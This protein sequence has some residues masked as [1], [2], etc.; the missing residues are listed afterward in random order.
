M[1]LRRRNVPSPQLSD[2]AVS[3]ALAVPPLPLQQALTDERNLLTV[4]W[5]L[6]LQGMEQTIATPTYF[7]G[8]HADRKDPDSDAANFRLGAY[9]YETDRKVLYQS[10]LVPLTDPAHPTDP[11]IPTPCWVYVAGTMSGTLASRPTD[12]GKPFFGTLVPPVPAYHHDDTGFRFHATD[13]NQDYLW[14]GTAWI[15]VTDYAYAVYGTHA[16]RLAHSLSTL[17]D[18]TLWCEIDRNNVLYQLQGG[19]WWYVSGTMYGTFTPDQR[20]TDLGVHEGGFEF[21]TTDFPARHFIWSQTAWVEVTPVSESNSMALALA[22]GTLT[23]TTS[24]QDILGATLTITKA[25]KYWLQGIF[26]FTMGGPD[27]GVLFQGVLA[28]NGTP[29]IQVAT[30]TPHYVSGPGGNRATVA[31]QWYTTLT[32][33]AVVKL[34]ASK[35]G[36]TGSSTAGATNTS[37]SAFWVSP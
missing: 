22:T 11:P 27:N 35:N 23:L 25:G 34:Q 32:V 7:E 21:R 8:T 12:L 10:R 1:A 20:P 24:L 33:G 15:D 36:G 2:A 16:A 5:T 37:L 31:Q 17:A 18:G 26:D 6:L 13:T 14:S 29:A 4:P 19:I 30:F 9:F 28:V 3:N